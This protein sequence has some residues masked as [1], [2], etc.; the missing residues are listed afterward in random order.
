[1]SNSRQAWRVFVLAGCLAATAA[2][3]Q[4][5]P[6]LA[7]RAVAAGTGNPYQRAR[8]LPAR[9]V[10]FTAQ[11]AAVRPGEPVVL[12]W[13]AE[14]PT[15]VTI[16]PGIGRV[17][18][19]GSRQVFPMATTKYTRTVKGADNQGLTRDLTVTV[20]GTAV[21]GTAAPA[22][23][24]NL[25]GVYDFTGLGPGGGPKPAE[26]SGAKAPVSREV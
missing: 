2:A 11:P 5:S 12:E 21:T 9:L 13:L 18:A 23:V 22:N 15:G 20:S 16:E 19:R 3:Q 4:S 24:P 1:M 6:P 17:I 26:N 14:N 10:T 25:S 8:Q 7:P